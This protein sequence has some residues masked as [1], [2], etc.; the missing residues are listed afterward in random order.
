MNVDKR[1]SKQPPVGIRSIVQN[2]P[3]FIRMFGHKT[4]L[5][6]NLSCSYI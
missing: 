1:I 5:M 2:L 3:V 6:Y 4:E